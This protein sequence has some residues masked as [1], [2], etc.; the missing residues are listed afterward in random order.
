[1]RDVTRKDVPQNRTIIATHAPGASTQLNYCNQ[2]RNALINIVFL[3][4][5]R[6]RCFAD[7]ELE[8]LLAFVDSEPA[9]RVI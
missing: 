2:K 3:V 5:S 7:N 4:E 9:P 8:P 1:M 6:H